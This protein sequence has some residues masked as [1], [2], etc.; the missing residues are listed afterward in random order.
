MTG[1][2]C[3]LV[4]G[5]LGMLLLPMSAALADE[6]PPERHD[7]QVDEL[8]LRYNLHPAFEKLGRGTSNFLAGWMEVPLNIQYRYTPHDAATSLFAGTA[9]GI[10]KGV[11]RTGVGLYEIVS[12]WLPYPENYAQILPTLD[13]FRRDEK[14][15]P[16]LFE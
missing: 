10:F 7:D 12:F 5:A 8:L 15:K 9:L 4:W 3:W 14:R 1:R 16:L 13:Y 11:V 2:R 6:R